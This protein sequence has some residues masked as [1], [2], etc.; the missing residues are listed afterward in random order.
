[1]SNSL[2]M[3]WTWTNEDNLGKGV[4]FEDKD[5][6]GQGNDFG[7]TIPSGSSSLK[8]PIAK[9]VEQYKRTRVM[10]AHLQDYV[11]TRDDDSDEVT[12]ELW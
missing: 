8:T 2:K 10:P 12:D 1:M 5:T 11:V 4:V 7:E 6:D 9:P 3:A